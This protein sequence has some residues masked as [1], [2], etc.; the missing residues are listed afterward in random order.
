[1][2]DECRVMISLVMLLTWL[3][4]RGLCWLMGAAKDVCPLIRHAGDV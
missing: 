3:A 1:M 4:S 2:L